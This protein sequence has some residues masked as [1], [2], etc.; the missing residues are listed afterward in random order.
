[1]KVT[2]QIKQPIYV[3]MAAFEDKFKEAMATKVPLLN[4]ITHY[5]V[6]RK[7]KQMRPMFVFLVAKMVSNG[8]FNERTYRGASIIVLI[9]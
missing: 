1:M 2:E 5:I 4:R 8:G 7:G 6:R 9:F 3:E